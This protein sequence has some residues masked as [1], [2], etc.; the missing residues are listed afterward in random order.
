VLACTESRHV[1]GV[2]VG[3]H[4]DIYAGLTLEPGEQVRAKRLTTDGRASARHPDRDRHD[5]LSSCASLSEVHERSSTVTD[6]VRV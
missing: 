2:S 6:P 3:S 4:G 1:H 5:L